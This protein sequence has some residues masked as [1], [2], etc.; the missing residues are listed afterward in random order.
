VMDFDFREKI[1]ASAHDDVSNKYNIK[2]V[3]TTYLK[4]LKK[5]G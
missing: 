5:L 2:N 4:V 3:I 1:T